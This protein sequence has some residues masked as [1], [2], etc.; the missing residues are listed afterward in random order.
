MHT[1][2]ITC[3]WLQVK[4]YF[5][6]RIQRDLSANEIVEHCVQWT[7]GRGFKVLWQMGNLGN[8]SIQNQLPLYARKT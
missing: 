2:K 6:N 4:T 7:F 3:E 5:F 1:I 8:S